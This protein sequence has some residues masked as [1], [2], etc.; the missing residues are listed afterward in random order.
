MKIKNKKKTLVAIACGIFGLFLLSGCTQSF[1]RNE[2]FAHM[3]YNIDSG[4]T[5]YVDINDQ[6]FKDNPTSFKKVFDDNENL[7]KRI[8]IDEL[9]YVYAINAVALSSDITIPSDDFFYAIDDKVFEN[10]W[11]LYG[12][13]SADA[14]LEDI[15]AF[16]DGKLDEEKQQVVCPGYGYLKFYNG[17]GSDLTVTTLWTNYDTW[18]QELKDEIGYQKCPNSDYLNLYKNSL[19]NLVKNTRTC[20]TT[21]PGGYFYGE[22]DPKVYYRS[23]NW[24]DAW[25]R[26]LLEGLIIF[27]V[28]W[29]VESMSF[30]FGLGGWGQ[31]GAIMIVTII[32]RLFFSLVTLKPTL[33]TQ[34][35]S[36]LSPELAKIQAKYPNANTNQA[37]KQRMAQE[38]SALYK[39][40]KVSM[41]STFIT[42]I[43][44][45]PLFLGVYGGMQGCAVLTSG[46]IFGLHLSD[47]PWSILQNTALFSTGGAGTWWTAFVLMFVLTAF[48]VVSMF[49]PQWIQK[50][51]NK[52]NPKLGKNPS[53]D[54]NSKRFRIISIVMLAGL[55]ITSFGLPAAMCIYWFGGAVFSILQTCLMQF[56]ILK[57]F[58]KQ[59]EN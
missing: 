22:T 15:T 28:A 56:V 18:V 36:Y 19:Y 8:N 29:A 12:K 13:A 3:M 9:S 30:V 17:N 38:T 7:Y 33:D 45:F 37:E 2:D 27:P 23:I 46:D 50:A 55:I 21:R 53:Q 58:R 10:F 24:G 6:K 35:M 49:L 31:V 57:R 47:T 5:E 44:Q 11:S 51:R 59:K 39:K 40:N 14:T 1:C 43:I 34:K 25:K 20:I 32:V 4:I 48:Q 54:Q 26:G 42:L 16:L 41:F 52:K